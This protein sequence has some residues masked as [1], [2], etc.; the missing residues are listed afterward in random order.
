[1]RRVLARFLRS[2]VRVG[3]VS[4]LLAA[5]AAAGCSGG[6]S[7]DQIYTPEPGD[8]GADV[9]VEADASKDT[10]V[11]G[12]DGAKDG[13]AG[14]VA[15]DK[16]DATDAPKDGDAAIDQADSSDSG[17][18]LDEEACSEN[19][20]LCNGV[21]DNCNGQIDEGDPGG[22]LPCDVPNKLGECKPGTTHCQNTQLKCVQNVPPAQEVCDGKDNDCDGTIDNNTTDTGGS[23]NTGNEGICAAGTET[24]EA[25]VKV[26]KQNLQPKTETCNGLDDDCNGTPDDGMPGA[27]QPCTVTGQ[28]PN[29]PCATG[30]TNC[31]G[32]QNGCTQTVFPASEVCDGKDND[33]NGTLD[34]PNLVE[35]KPCQTG[36]PGICAPGKTL[37][38]AG[39]PSC[40]PDIAPGSTVEVCNAKD[41]DCNGQ[42]DDIVNVKLE[43]ATKYPT[44]QNVL[45][46]Q[47]STGNCQVTV[48]A[49]SYKDCDGAPANG[50]EVN[51]LNDL[52]HCAVC[53]HMCNASHG[54]PSCVA[55]Q[56]QISCASG[57]GNCDNDA[58]TGC[59]LPVTSDINNC[60][61]CTHKCESTT[62][63]PS[64]NNGICS[65]VCTSGLGNCDGNVDNGCETNLGTDPQHCGSCTNV[66]SSVGG[67][68]SCVASTCNITCN[69]GLGNC[70]NN[71]ANGCEVNTN[72]DPGNCGSCGHLCSTVNGTPGCFGG[73]CTITC[74]SG[75]GN[76]DANVTNG[77]ETNLKTSPANCNGCGNACSTNHGTPGCSNG[78][79]SISCSAG[80]GN[81]DNDVTDGCEQSLTNDPNHCGTCVKV[82]SSNH[83]TPS[84]VN[85]VCQI[86]CAAGYADC[87]GDAND[88]CEVNL[89]TDAVHCGTC[90]K[91]CS[92]NNGIPSCVSGS[93]NISCS[94]GFG[95]CDGNVDNGCEVDLKSS[96]A[97]CNA[98]GAACNNTNGTPSC[99]AGA[100]QIACSAGF[101]N[102]DN[103]PGNGCEINLNTNVAHCGS[104]PKV[105]SSVNGTPSCAGGTCSIACNPNFANCDN[106]VD[107]G[108]EADLKNDEQHCG[109]CTT[110][111]SSS[112]GT[113]SCNNG[114]CGITCA[115]GYGDC[116]GNTVNGCETNINTNLSHCGGCG[117]VCSNANGNPSCNGGACGITC[118]AGFGNC[119]GNV[120]NGC[121]INLNTDPIHC[122]TCAKICNGTNGTPGCASGACTIACATGFANCDGS[123]DN[124][125]EVNL[126][127][128]PQHCNSCS[129]VCNGTNGTATCTNGACGINCNPG[130]GNCDGNLGNGCETNI[131]SN[132]SHC[133]G[134]GN[135]CST[136]NGSP[137]CASGSCSITC[138]AG[139]GN[140]NN[141]AADGCEINTTNNP[142]HCNGCGQACSNNNGTPSCSGGTCSIA[143]NPGWGNCDN[144]A[145]NGC[146]VNTTNDVSHCGS[147][148]K[149]CSS[150]NGTPSCVGSACTIACAAGWGNC[151]N[152]A[153]T[154]CEVNITNN[155]NNCGACGTAC[156]GTNGTPSCAG[157][158][159]SISCN[160]GFGNCDGSAANG[161]EVTFAND[162]A[163]CGNCTTNCSSPLPAHTLGAGCSGGGCT[164]ST[165]EGGYYNQDN[166][167]ANGCE[168]Q[169]D[170]VQNTCA[171]ATS[172]GD[173]A[174][175]GTTTRT[176]NLSPT[177]DNDW[178]VVR[179]A[180]GPSCSF[181]PKIALSNSGQPI[182]MNVFTNCSSGTIPC[183]DNGN[184][185]NNSTIWE[186]TYSASCG[187]W[188]AID[189][190]P[191][192]TQP[193][194]GVNMPTPVGGYITLYINVKATASVPACLDYTLTITN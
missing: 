131:N 77:C 183:S 48:C 19:F 45:D 180:V 32:G 162:P 132:T 173:V 17:D 70:D 68:P 92:N 191:D 16:A 5:A 40:N 81:C 80:W 129:T 4:S 145:G 149:V 178:Y 135:A 148:P 164:I 29:T 96:T 36:L 105:C 72:T 85:S 101:G 134:C 89:N 189:Y 124:G 166:A 38:N 123:A 146:E 30:L 8:G 25:S 79:C 55:G 37:C 97:N 102:C 114:T 167:F 49:G 137:A 33:C 63:T 158:N 108:C 95:N 86:A 121:E 88:G 73:N 182:V 104:C 42:V 142:S 99:V 2:V 75:Y 112:G 15:L 7:A 119:D 57:W 161:C 41:D 47:C 59:E 190:S 130:Y 177:T 64:C 125:C 154:G 185:G 43:C 143:C 181:N 28:L 10:K 175:N 83:G 54:T 165:C 12:P 184:S 98:C 194:I 188:L 87:N 94:S 187:A 138:N 159:C 118:T 144:N 152:N 35:G 27:G 56:C 18:A 13:E 150:L 111:C 174:V 170:G 69:A 78:A 6:D 192:I 51:A 82:C 91:I 71:V 171:S 133:G 46:W 26:C 122:G 136:V 76:C 179:F 141:N 113:P 50:C 23:C 157:S 116:D 168:C 20:E 34:D 60:G 1:M 153:D 120:A 52:N 115:S 193:F 67:A 24:C 117:H 156:N 155:V 53:G 103:N 160:G 107:T 74:T 65:I 11:D 84:C 61:A 39:T 14:D 126:K 151:D 169:D 58:E 90:A 172:L 110:I 139:F 44:A 62:G 66:C 100:C 22:N 163:H 31:L 21:D 106:N 9:T 127:T 109:N 128:D 176:G 93:C 3:A 140:C 147:C 186:F